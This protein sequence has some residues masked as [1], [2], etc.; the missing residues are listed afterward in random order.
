MTVCADA[1]AETEIAPDIDADVP[2]AEPVPSGPRTTLVHLFEWSWP[3][4]AIECETVLG[5]AGYAGVQVSPPQEYGL[6]DGSPWWERYQ[7]ASYRIA[8]RSGDEAAF[9]NMVARCDA[10]GVAVFFKFIF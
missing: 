8:G 7:P 5:P 6:I 1:D 4:I 2:D 3:A 9:A 10:V